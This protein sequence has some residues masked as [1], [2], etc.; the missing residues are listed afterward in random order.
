M[1]TQFF[2]NYLLSHKIVTRSELFSAMERMEHGH[3]RLGTLAI[4]EGY[5]V[6]GEVDEVVIEQTHTDRKFGEISIDLGFLTREQVVELLHMQSLDYLLLGQTLVDDGILTTH[7]LE[8]IIADYKSENKL[9]DLDLAEDNHINVERMF[10]H[11]FILS[12]LTVSRY[13]KLYMELLFNNFVRFV[14][15]DFAA[16]DAE[17]VTEFPPDCCV[18][19][20]VD[21][22][23]TVTSYISMDPP[24]AVAFASRY[25]RDT[26]LEYDEYVQASLEDFLN[27]HNGLFIVNA[28]NIASLELTL[29]APET[30]TEPL[31]TFTNR[32][33]HFPILYSFG[34]VH[35]VL[36]VIRM[37]E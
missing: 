29:T 22:V 14:G 18:C 16:L 26:F 24:T 35:F 23:Y 34:T 7:Q 30:V 36:E 11:L 27:L 15:E 10:D 9:Y 4:H 8:N 37:P 32:T 5:M 28:S 1:Y 2:G 12:E 17:A 31:L 33:Y 13:G 6:S 25:V 3:M 20:K 21:G 19:Q